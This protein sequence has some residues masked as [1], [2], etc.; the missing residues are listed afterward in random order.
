MIDWFERWT[1]YCPDKVAVEEYETGRAYSYAQFNVLGNQLRGWMWS[2]MSI[3]KGDRIV[4]L[5]DNCLEHIAL[6]ATA[7]KS[8]IILVPLNHRLTTPDLDFLISNC[9]PSMI[10]CEEKYLPKIQ[11]SEAYEKV[12]FKFTLSQFQERCS[13]LLADEPYNTFNSNT[14]SEN[15]PLFLIY[16]SGTTGFPKGA[17]Y[18]HKM[19]FWNSINTMMRLDITSSDRSINCTP[20][21]HT[22]SW[23]VLQTPFIH[24][25]AY[26]L[27]MKGFEPEKVLQCLEQKK[28]TIFWAVPTMLKMMVMADSFEKVDFGAIRY[29]VVGGEAMPVSMIELW[30][31]RGVLIRQGY[32]LTEVGPNVTSLDAADA[33]RKQGS[34]GKPNFYYQMKLVDELGLEVQTGN[35]GECILYGPTVTPG[36]WKNP[37]ATA[38]A[39]IDGWFHTGDLMQCDNEGYYY[40]VDRLK[41]IYISG[42]ENIYPAEVEHAIQTHPAVHAVAVIGVRHEKWGEV[43]KAFIV[44][45]KNESATAEQLIEY[46]NTRL[47]KYKTPKYFEFVE[48]LPLNAS[49]KID[50]KRLKSTTS[51]ETY[52]SE[53]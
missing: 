46:C 38:E 5:A 7:Q 12:S 25:G 10:I 49:G 44:L 15:D 22:G 35:T 39:I 50:R 28:M 8:G 14:P 33:I 21:F 18:T 19:L 13:T 11:P 6:F 1:S 20:P 2:E 27:L 42:G 16:T 52:T 24:H 41:N 45:N 34:I 51:D 53:N 30:H 31:R 43:G 17:I 26:T 36:Y 37:E 48:S 40:I 9:D 29:F 47:A 23:N 3:A 4:I 32:G